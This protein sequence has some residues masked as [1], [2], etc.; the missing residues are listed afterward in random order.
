MAQGDWHGVNPLR[1]ALA[2]C[3]RAP[4]TVQ[5]LDSDIVVPA[6]LGDTFGFFAEAGNLERL[7]P[8]WLNFTILTPLPLAMREG[9]EIDY[10]IRLHG[11][12]IPWRTRIDEWVPGASFVD[13]QTMGPYRWWRHEHRFEEE[14]GGTRVIDR[15]EYTPRARWASSWLVRRDLERIF[16]YRRDAMRTIFSRQR[17]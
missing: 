8:P 5:V 14:V 17:T 6:T 2:A 10:R 4:R 11:L 12:P 7:T 9:V 3:D 16:A 13:R 1:W 15:V